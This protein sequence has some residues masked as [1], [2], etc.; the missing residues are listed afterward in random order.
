VITHRL[1]YTDF[2]SGFDAMN[3]GEASKVILNWD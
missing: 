2:Q 1:H 3:A